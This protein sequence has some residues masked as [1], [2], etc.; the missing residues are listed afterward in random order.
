MPDTNCVTTQGADSH[1]VGFPP[2]AA[3]GTVAQF[4]IEIRHIDGS[5]DLKALTSARSARASKSRTR[6]AQNGRIAGMLEGL[7]APTQGKVKQRSSGIS[8]R[9]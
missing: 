5:T 9:Q 7:P 8:I 4:H 6:G 1:G 2:A 3:I